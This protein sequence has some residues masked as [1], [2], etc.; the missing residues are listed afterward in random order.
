MKLLW[1]NCKLMHVELK[2]TLPILQTQVS[3]ATDAA[4]VAVTPNRK[5]GIF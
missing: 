3:I 5:Q 2:W 4:Y 1:Y